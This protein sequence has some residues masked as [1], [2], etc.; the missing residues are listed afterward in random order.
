MSHSYICAVCQGEFVDEDF[1]AALDEAAATFAPVELRDSY[2]VCDDCWRDMRE[3]HPPHHR[4]RP[5][6][7]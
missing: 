2:V 7:S 5:C 3:K 6:L 1:D 4:A